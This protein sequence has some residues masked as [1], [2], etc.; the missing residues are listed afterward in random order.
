MAPSQSSTK[1]FISLF[2]KGFETRVNVPQE[3][4]HGFPPSKQAASFLL[5]VSSQCSLVIISKQS[6]IVDLKWHISIH[7]L[8]IVHVQMTVT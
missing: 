1:K 5:S 8:I 7:L 3:E 4:S 2:G 6:T